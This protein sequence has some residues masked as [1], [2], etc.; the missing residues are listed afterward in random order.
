[1]GLA[2]K[3]WASRARTS[4]TMGSGESKK[5]RTFFEMVMQGYTIEEQYFF[6]MSVMDTPMHMLVLNST[7]FIEYLSPDYRENACLI[8]IT[9]DKYKVKYHHLLSG[10]VESDMLGHIFDGVSPPTVGLADLGVC[11]DLFEISAK[12]LMLT[13]SLNDQDVDEQVLKQINIVGE[14]GVKLIDSSNFKII[15]MSMNKSVSL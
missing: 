7:E 14:I 3:R 12:H 2:R 5:I 11:R 1:M 13:Y 9:P 15:I 8:E 10:F 4:A 6:H